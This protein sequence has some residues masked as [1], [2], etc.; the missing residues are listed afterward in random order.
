MAERGGQPG[1]QNGVK[2]RP[3][4]DAIR[5][6]LMANDGQKLRAIAVKLTTMAAKGD[7]AAIREVMDRIDG[8]PKQQVE[9]SGPNGGDIP[10]R[11]ATR[12]MGVARTVAFALAMG[13]LA[14]AKESSQAAEV[15]N[16]AHQK[17]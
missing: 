2:N 1:N 4:V 11:D 16:A 17:G 10:I 3:F 15:A 6:A 5:L 12:S 7:I 9:M 8:K 14:K 13:A